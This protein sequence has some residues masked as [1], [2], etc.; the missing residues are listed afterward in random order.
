MNS[1]DVL[2]RAAEIIEHNGWAQGQYF[3]PEFG[4]APEDCR[5]CAIGAINVALYAAKPTVLPSQERTFPL[6]SVV[7]WYLDVYD[8]A[9]WN[10]AKD[11]T[12]EE[13][14]AAL[15]GA[16]ADERERAR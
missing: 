9:E 5:V 11:R 12:A 16:A 3:V 2:D 14:I 15:R 6:S 4:K 7:E 8:L 13:V 10:D 1:A